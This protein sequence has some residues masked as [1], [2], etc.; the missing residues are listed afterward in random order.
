MT[1]GASP[2]DP[3]AGRACLS[4]NLRR[5]FERPSRGD[6]VTWG[7]LLVAVCFVVYANGL[8]GTFTYDDKA[9]VRDN[10]RLRTPARVREI[11]RTSY[12]G[13]GQGSGS[14]YRPVL[15]LSYAA[16]WWIHGR[17]APGFHVVNVALHAA[18]T[19]LLAGLFLRIG[20]PP[21]AVALSSLLFAAHPVHVEAVTSLV[22]RGETLAAILTAGFLHLAL[23]FSESGG[24]RR[25]T[26]LAGALALYALALLTKESASVAPA[27]LFLLLAFV[28]EGSLPR[29]LAR[30]L[31]RG[32]PVYAGGAALLAGSFMLRAAVLGGPIRPPNSGI[33][34]VENA[35]APLHAWARVGNACLILLR[36]LGRCVFPLHLSADESAWSIRALAPGA[37]LVLLAVA[38]VLLL[39]GLA[40]ARLP[41]GSPAALGVLWFGVAFL[42][43][44]NLLFPIGTIFAERVAYL[45]SAGVCLAL[46][47]ACV[48]AS[49]SLGELST[50]RRRVAAAAVVALSIRTVTRNAVW[51]TDSSLFTNSVAVAPASAKAHYN[52]AFVLGEGRRFREAV[53]HYERAVSIYD[54]YWD[55]WAGKGKME[56]ELGLLSA[57]EASYRKALALFPDYENG[58]FGL[59]VV[60]EAQGRLSDAAAD[61]R[62]GLAKKADSLPLAYRLAVVLSRMDAPDADA[63]WRRAVALGPAS[64]A[65]RGDHSEWLLRAGSEDEALREARAALRLD[66]AYPAAW[67]ALAR[68]A[69]LR[70]DRLARALALERAA[71][72]SGDPEDLRALDEASTSVPAYGARFERVRALLERRASSRQ[73]R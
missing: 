42:P 32:W 68:S 71:L 31:S 45:P 19:L 14:N 24:R 8:T 39:A 70:G 66:P 16:E 36:Y 43:T 60:L 18:A 46:G 52:H 27:L 57:A 58:F 22:G 59:G 7:F 3:R 17:S 44:A 30:A 2:P 1:G 49:R 28:F 41:S 20:L 50:G 11:F 61:Y 56:R 35:L 6:R 55:A 64:A 4:D 26:A 12:F 48:G 72:A 67:R 25:W 63:A 15:L 29:R 23:T 65:V 40:L 69:E 13:G 9:I 62:R 47:A 53:G 51:W 33:F 34:E 21:P 54:G 10:P 37:P 73:S 38:L 5:M